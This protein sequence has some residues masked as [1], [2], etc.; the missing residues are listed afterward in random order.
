MFCRKFLMFYKAY[1]EVKG[2]R[3]NSNTYVF[4]TQFAL[5]VSGLDVK[6]SQIRSDPWCSVNDQHNFTPIQ[7]NCTN[8]AHNYQPAIIKREYNIQYKHI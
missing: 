1:T 7:T 5:V 6:V 2:I 4:K 3:I 8:R